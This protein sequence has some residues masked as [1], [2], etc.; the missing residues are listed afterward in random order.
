MEHDGEVACFQRR[1]V[2]EVW[3]GLFEASPLSVDPRGLD[4]GWSEGWA[5]SECCFQFSHFLLP[6]LQLIVHHSCHPS[7]S[8]MS[9]VA[10]E[11]KDMRMRMREAGVGRW[12]VRSGR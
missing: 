10:L 2:E 5:D 6:L 11:M 1:E 12:E 8:P 3:D 9:H 4:G 7:V